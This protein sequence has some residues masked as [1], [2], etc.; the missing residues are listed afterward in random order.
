MQADILVEKTYLPFHTK[1]FYCAFLASSLGVWVLLLLFF[2][3]LVCLVDGG[4]LDV[5]GK[6]QC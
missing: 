3:C 2:P 5:L 1:D 4:Q 6:C